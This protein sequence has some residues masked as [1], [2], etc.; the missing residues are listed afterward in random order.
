MLIEIGSS[1]IAEHKQAGLVPS[2]TKCK[3]H[4]SMG[5]NL[6]AVPCYSDILDDLDT[7]DE[8]GCRQ[9]LVTSEA[10]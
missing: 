5:I 3:N 1:T 9:V 2:Y 4:K 8:S 7:E 10:G 6:L